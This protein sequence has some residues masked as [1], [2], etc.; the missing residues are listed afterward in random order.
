MATAQPSLCARLMIVIHRWYRGRLSETAGN[1]QTMRRVVTLL[2]MMLRM[3][4]STTLFAQRLL[5]LDFVFYFC[6]FRRHWNCLSL[7]SHRLSRRFHHWIPTLI[8]RI[9]VAII[10]VGP[11]TLRFIIADAV[12]ANIS[13]ATAVLLLSFT[14]RIGKA[15]RLETYLIGRCIA[16]PYV[17]EFCAR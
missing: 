5:W 3:G 16:L 1:A 11:S 12:T 9:N 4:S 6:Q 2:E 17:L 8:L 13:D 10:T 15:L 14:I 7:C